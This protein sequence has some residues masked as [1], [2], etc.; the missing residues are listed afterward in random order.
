MKKYLAIILVI[1]ILF[2]GCK[3]SKSLGF[4]ISSGVKTFDPQ[5]ASSD[6]ELV[7]IKNCFQ[8]LMDKDRTGALILGVCKSYN[9]SE[10]GK[11]YTFYIK[12]GLKWNDGETPLTADDFVFAFQRI[13]R[14]ET[15]APSKSD[16]FNIKNARSISEGKL[17]IE[18]LGVKAIDPY[19]LEIELENADP[20]FLDLLTTAAA[21]PC[22]KNFFESTKGRY[23]LGLSYILFNGAFYVRRINNTSY[24]LSPNE[25]SDIANKK[26]DNIYLFVKD[27]PKQNAVSR[28]SEETVD[29]AV[30]DK[31][32]VDI[33]E[34]AG[35][36]I[37]ES[38]NTTWLLAFNTKNEYLENGNIRKAISYAINKSLFE[39]KIGEHLRVSNAY[40]PSAVTLN[41]TSY[42]KTVGDSFTGFSQ[43]TKMSQELYAKGLAELGKEKIPT[44]TIICTEEFVPAMGYVQKGIQDSLS[45]FVNLVQ[46][47]PEE[48]ET[49]LANGNYDMA[50]TSITPR[51]DNPSSV[52]SL[53]TDESNFTHFSDD[54]LTKAISVAM[55]K[56]NIED[57]ADSFSVAEQILLQDMPALPLFYETSYFAVSPNISGL[58]YS[59]F[60][61]HIVFRFCK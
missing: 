3:K 35:F 41:G 48:L 57:M 4:D 36:K 12:N 31:N 33:L 40:V 60:G 21:M 14:K 13:F 58:D 30:I 8:G 29:A 7:I 24:V 11:K 2:S 43:N 61:G 5:L 15:A 1:L 17:S 23:G 18:K 16:F 51:Y 59:V 44:L 34:N 46:V 6:S 54:N 45:F 22:N 25:S 37:H 52:L 55:H 19:T 32:D 56:S 50:V 9:A 49:K 53:F 47:T 26:Y 39:D 10:D 38:E 27:N 42:R 20:Q 28:L